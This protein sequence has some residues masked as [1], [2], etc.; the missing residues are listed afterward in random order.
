MNPFDA[1]VGHIVTFDQTN[2][3]STLRLEIGEY[4]DAKPLFGL[5]MRCKHINLDDNPWEYP[6]VPV[7]AGGL[8]KIREY[9]EELKPPTKPWKTESLK[10]VFAGHSGAGKTR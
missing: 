1:R 4:D 7:V 8:D 9:Y 5:L 10:V 2:V 6:P 3:P